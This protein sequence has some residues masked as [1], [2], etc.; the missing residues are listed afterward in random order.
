MNKFRTGCCLTGPG[1]R[2]E[3][4]RLV[5]LTD[6]SQSQQRWRPEKSWLPLLTG[7]KNTLLWVCLALVAEHSSRS[8]REVAFAQ[9]SSFLRGKSEDLKQQNNVQLVWMLN[10]LTLMK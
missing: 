5:N 10:M 1:R 7:E 2:K 6:S 8:M 3:L 4:E 9:N